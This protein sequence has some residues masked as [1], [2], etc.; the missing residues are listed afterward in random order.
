MYKD[1]FTVPVP[2]YDNYRPVNGTKLTLEMSREDC[3]NTYDKLLAQYSDYD[4]IL[5]NNPIIFLNK[6]S[7]LRLFC[8]NSGYIEFDVQRT[9]P[10]KRNGLEAELN[11]KI[12]VEVQENIDDSYK[13]TR[14]EIICHRYSFPV[15]YGKEECI[16]RYGKDISFLE[17]R[18]NLTVVFPVEM[19][20]ILK[21]Q[22]RLYSFLPTQVKTNAPV[23]LHV[24]YKLNGSR[25]YVHSQGNNAWFKFTNEKLRIL[26]HRSY[27]DLAKCLKQ[28]I[29]YYIPKKHVDFFKNDN[30]K[31][32]CLLL[33]GIHSNILCQLN[34]FYAEDGTYNSIEKIV[35]FGYCEK[36]DD[37]N[38]VYGLLGRKE[39]LFIPPSSIDMKWFGC[40]TIDNISEVL[41][42]C[43]IKNEELF[44]EILTWLEKNDSDLRYD[45]LIEKNEPISLGSLHIQAIANNDRIKRAF[46]KSVSKHLRS[47]SN[48]SMPPYFLKEKSQKYGSKSRDEIRN[49]VH[50]A[51]LEECFVSYLNKIDFM[52]FKCESEKKIALATSDGIVLSVGHEYS[53][54]SDLSSY[55]DERGT[56]SASLKI[57]QASRKLNKI[58]ENISNTDYLK[59]LREV[60]RSLRNILG[61][62]NYSTYVRILIEAGA[63]NNR[64]FSEI[65]QNADDCSYPEDVIPEMILR[66]EDDNLVVTYNEEGFT[67][68]NVRAI[69]AIGE[70]TKKMLLAS[71]HNTIGEK[72]VGF[73]T[74]FGVASSVE[75]HSNGFDFVLTDQ[76]PTIPDKCAS[77]PM[78]RG[79]Y[80]SFR[81]KK[82]IE[83]FFSTKRLLELCLCLRRLKRITIGNHS[84]TIDDDENFRRIVVDGVESKFGRFAYDFH[85]DN[86]LLH[87][88][89]NGFN[90]YGQD[91]KIIFYLPSSKNVSELTL[92]TGLPLLVKCNI[93]LIIDA[94]F[95]LTTSRENVLENE[96][97]RVVRQNIYKGIIKLMLSQPK[98]KLDVLRFVHLSSKGNITSIQL[99]ENDF[100]CR[101]QWLDE[102][103]KAKI[104]PVLGKEERVSV[105]SGRCLLIP[106]FIGKLYQKINLQFF[107]QGFIV[108]SIGKTQ[109]TSILEHIG[110]VKVNGITISR[111]LQKY[112]SSLIVNEIFRKGLYDYLSGNQGNVFFEGIGNT[113][114]SIPIFPIRTT[115][116]TRYICYTESL[117][118]HK[119]EIS[120]DEY[121][122]LDTNTMS[123]GMADSILKSTHSRV[124]ELTQEVLDAKYQKRVEDLIENKKKYRSNKEIFTILLDEYR[125]NSNAFIKCKNILRGLKSKVPLLMS[126]KT[127]RTGNKYLNQSDQFYAGKIIPS[128]IVDN[129]SKKIGELLELS[130]IRGIHY[131]DIKQELSFVSNDDIEDFEC[132]F[133]NYFDLM[134][135]M[136]EDGLLTDE[137][138]STYHL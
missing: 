63:N 38:Y 14:K 31:V 76:T 72:G 96:W 84:V 120:N 137:Q 94:P 124:K 125:N 105:S 70:S 23:I 127:I 111:F 66:F 87:V 55:F 108:D 135:G 93:P 60:R 12:A 85:V 92:Y 75:I 20:G 61:E 83:D 109:Y 21:F 45:K 30:E 106:E 91:Q 15:I 73:K 98:Q 122:I 88:Q 121:K 32:R 2:E 43:G 104:I 8:D 41:F 48:S 49:L 99:F 126:D 101:E 68:N 102:L 36:I 5:N 129:S 22:G 64:F 47:K 79:T 42:A 28:K 82:K 89:K 133:Q 13:I 119:T 46:M 132:D 103:K 17:K 95:E 33:P 25:E 50:N 16:S 29:V 1:N 6:L 80:M 138:I 4:S 115:L 107:F 131:S 81:M 26:L 34:I 110:C 90:K 53:S 18:H 130:D 39:K 114:L 128:L 54:F 62:E 44:E 51:D 97:N 69:T 3:K 58:D 86:E 77:L 118:H 65:L 113:V 35:A 100:L 52:F 59:I 24:P 27:E 71:D 11:I 37:P 19:E 57:M 78:E 116:G 10:I 117:Y 67:K 123:I 74:V 112:A 56:F 136:Y 40:K 9:N 134:C 7:H